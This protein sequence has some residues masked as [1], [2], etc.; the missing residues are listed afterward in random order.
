MTAKELKELEKLGQLWATQKAT[1]K[2][3]ERYMELSRKRELELQQQAKITMKRTGDR[4][5][6]INQNG[7]A[8][9]SLYDNEDKIMFDQ[10]ADSRELFGIDEKT[11]WPK[12]FAK[13]GITVLSVR[14]SDI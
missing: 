1:K 10:M 7:V 9:A 8:I 11:D 2:Q 12:Y 5:D 3:I 13:N 6:F 4:V 14:L